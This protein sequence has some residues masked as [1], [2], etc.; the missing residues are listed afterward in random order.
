MGVSGRAHILKICFAKRPFVSGQRSRTGFA[1]GEKEH[2]KRRENGESE[3]AKLS[4]GHRGIA[5]VINSYSQATATII[6]VQYI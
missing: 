5:G 3:V 6:L 2:Y 1:R 4:L